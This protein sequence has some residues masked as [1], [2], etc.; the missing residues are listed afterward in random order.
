MSVSSSSL[1]VWYDASFGD[2]GRFICSNC[3]GTAFYGLDVVAPEFWP[4]SCDVCA[5]RLAGVSAPVRVSVDRSL[6]FEEL[7]ARNAELAALDAV[8]AVQPAR[9]DFEA[10][11]IIARESAAALRLAAVA[12]GIAF[13]AFAAG[14]GAPGRFVGAAAALAVL[15]EARGV[16]AFNMAAREGALEARNVAIALAAAL[17]VESSRAAARWSAVGFAELAA[18]VD[19]L[20]EEDEAARVLLPAP[21]SAR[22]AA[23]R[24][25][26]DT[27]AGN[28]AAAADRE[29][30]ARVV[31]ARPVFSVW[32][33]TKGVSL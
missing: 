29:E 24:F 1:S 8:D 7:A 21:V 26:V 13:E 11:D 31:A 27:A 16:A 4:S 23:S 5:V 6:S 2:C 22:V 12:E 17:M 30:L 3:A 32:A 33:D 20:A 10:W 19:F 14:N 28:A 15:E 18:A 25:A 9:D